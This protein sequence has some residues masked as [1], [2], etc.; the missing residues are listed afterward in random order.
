MEAETLSTR[1]LLVKEG[2]VAAKSDAD[3]LW[4]G[5]AQG[6]VHRGEEG[7]EENHVLEGHYNAPA[8]EE[9]VLI[10]GGLT[11]DRAKAGLKR[12]FLDLAD[13]EVVG[14]GRQVLHVQ[15]RFWRGILQELLQ[16]AS[17]ED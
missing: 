16:H 6:V 13:R 9:G 15:F 8:V 14:E 1:P 5:G 3:L 4:E 12:P 7:N 17:D 2:L 11:E 10:I